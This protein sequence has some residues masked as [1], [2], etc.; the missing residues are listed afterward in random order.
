MVNQ[1]GAFINT[2]TGEKVSSSVNYKRDMNEGGPLVMFSAT[3]G[4]VT[5]DSIEGNYPVVNIG[6]QTES[7]IPVVS[8]D[9]PIF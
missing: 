5:L 1:S 7:D 8:F 9:D 2:M 3:S 4:R 6:K